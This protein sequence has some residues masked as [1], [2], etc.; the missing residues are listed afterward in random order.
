MIEKMRIACPIDAMKVKA[1][2]IG[3][4]GSEPLELSLVQIRNER[5]MIVFREVNELK[6][7]AFNSQ[8]F[9]GSRNNRV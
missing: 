6:C 1:K 9:H 3:A 8:E 5:Q 4:L 7:A 2:K